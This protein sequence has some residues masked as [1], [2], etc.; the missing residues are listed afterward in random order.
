MRT[1]ERSHR[2][3]IGLRGAVDFGVP[4]RRQKL[5]LP[6]WRILPML[7]VRERGTARFVPNDQGY[8]NNFVEVQRT[9]EF[10]S[11]RTWAVAAGELLITLGNFVFSRFGRHERNLLLVWLPRRCVAIES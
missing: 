10:C 1:S 2:I 7:L 5:A 3:E 6:Q 8:G 9:Q 11:R 4:L